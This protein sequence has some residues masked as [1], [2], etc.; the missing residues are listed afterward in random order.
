MN[1]PRLAVRAGVGLAALAWWAPAILLAVAALLVDR[2][3]AVGTLVLVDLLRAAGCRARPAA[4]RPRWPP[5]WSAC[6]RAAVSAAKGMLRDAKASAPGQ[7]ADKVGAAVAPEE[8]ENAVG[9]MLKTGTGGAIRGDQNS[10]RG[11][12]PP[13]PTA[14]ARRTGRARCRK[15]RQWGHYRFRRQ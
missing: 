7:F 4:C 13:R 2:A 9:G 12:R 5:R 15:I 8:V 1:A 3:R 14:R 6:G 10:R 11:I